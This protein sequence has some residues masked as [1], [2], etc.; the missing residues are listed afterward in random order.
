MSSG[1]IR[2][3]GYC[4]V[5]SSRASQSNASTPLPV[6]E[7]CNERNR[8]PLYNNSTCSNVAHGNCGSTE[9]LDCSWLRPIFN[10]P[11]SLGQINQQVVQ[12]IR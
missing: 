12:F 11:T 2:Q 9:I 7:F 6:M 1:K 3:W 10:I 5:Q 8:L 4:R